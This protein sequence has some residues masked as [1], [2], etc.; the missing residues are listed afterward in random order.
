M[1]TALAQLVSRLEVI[2][3]SGHRQ[4][5]EAILRSQ[6]GSDLSG[7]IMEITARVEMLDVSRTKESKLRTSVQTHVL[8]SLR[9][10]EMTNRYENVL[11]AYPNTFEWAF[12]DSTKEQLPWNNLARWLKEGYGIYWISGK[13]GSGKSTLMKHVFDDTRTRQ[14]LEYWAQKAA[15]HAAPLCLA[16][17]FFWNSGSFEQKSQGGMLRTL[18]CQVLDQYP[19]LL[20]VIFPERWARAY[21]RELSG[22]PHNRLSWSLHECIEAFK[23][24]LQQSSVPLKVCLLID[25]LDE[26]NGDHDDLAELCKNMTKTESQGIKICLSSR[27]W[28]VFQ[29]SFRTYP[30]LRLQDLTYG[31]IDHYVSDKF[32]RNTAFQRLMAREPDLAPA[33]IKE[34]AHCADGVFLWVRLVV[35]SLLDGIRNR[36]AMP[37]LLRRLR[38]IPRE[39]EPLYQHL[40]GLIDPIYMEWASAAFE[41]VRAARDLEVSPFGKSIGGKGVQPVTLLAFHL[42]MSRDINTSN[43]EHI[44]ETTLSTECQDTAVHITARCCGLLEISQLES[45]DGGIPGQQSL[46]QFF[47]LTV[48]EF[49]EKRAG[50]PRLQGDKYSIEFEPHFAL[51]R[52][53][54]L[55]LGTQY[56]L[57][58]GLLKDINN[59]AYS[60]LIYAYHADIHADVQH[61]QQVQLELLAYVGRIVDQY[62]SFWH[63]T[64]VNRIRDK[65]MVWEDILSEVF[66]L[67]PNAAGAD[68]DIQVSYLR[69]AKVLLSSGADPKVRPLC[70]G[71]GRISAL[72]LLQKH[73]KF[74]FPK[75]ADSLLI[76]LNRQLDSRKSLRRAATGEQEENPRVAKRRRVCISETVN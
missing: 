9:F 53:H 4:T 61:T 40:L 35:K 37:D 29:D 75:E 55:L 56:S 12:R 2:Y 48:R 51:L 28:V 49:F 3:Q 72:E 64:F 25:G 63:D 8:K 7:D 33:L 38:Q 34:I 66:R 65:A 32:R 5:R 50:W 54:A 73:M 42:A 23:A 1:T 70:G 68:Y 10:P 45:M 30:K 20:P 60:A 14:Y 31:D 18:L 15:P 22:T 47:H 69:I 71:I 57:R 24:L 62:F 59:T 11:E 76:E 44:T 52:S 19:D 39:L 58:P 36:D 46:V 74:G 43:V 6:R 16:T 17:F 27:P 41:I 67:G 26:C 13:S 21:S